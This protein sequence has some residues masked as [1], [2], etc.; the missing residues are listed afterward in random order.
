MALSFI[1]ADID[2]LIV[3]LQALGKALKVLP[4]PCPNCL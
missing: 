3:D 2:G 1:G 4:P